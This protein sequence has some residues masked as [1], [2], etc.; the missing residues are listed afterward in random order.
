MSKNHNSALK[1]REVI[2]NH[3]QKSL[4]LRR[5][6]GPFSTPPFTPF[7]SSPLGVVPKSE[8]GKFRI[9]HD[10]SYPKDNSVNINIPKEN[11]AV[12]YDTIDLIIQ[13]VQNY[14][15]N[16]LMAKTD[17][18]DAFRIIPVNPADY[19]L[20][21]FSWENEFY[22][23]RCLPMGASS[24]CQIFERVSVALQWVMQ[25]KYKA[26]AMSHILDDF[27]SSVQLIHRAAKMILQIF[28]TFA[29]PLGSL[30]KCQKLKLLPHQSLYMALKLTHAKWKHVFLLKKLIRLENIF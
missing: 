2:E 29:K 20:L 12:Q 11:S 14:G 19:H 9:I 26:G 21:G 28:S 7:V 18:E 6:A 3:I 1:H 8:P 30:L 10:L 23:D 22:F 5:I 15:E 25:S 17:I 4:N 27:S 16:C 24:S 13:L